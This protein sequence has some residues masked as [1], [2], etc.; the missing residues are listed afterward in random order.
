LQSGVEWHSL[1][2]ALEVMTP[3]LVLMFERPWQ[4]KQGRSPDLRSDSM[5]AA[6]G[7]HVTRTSIKIPQAIPDPFHIFAFIRLIFPHMKLQVVEG[8]WNG[9][10]FY[11]YPDRIYRIDGILLACGEMSSAVGRSILNIR[12]VLPAL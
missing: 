1:Q 8:M 7:T 5:P 12:L 9:F 6:N 4:S 11:F 3:A 2:K 10:G